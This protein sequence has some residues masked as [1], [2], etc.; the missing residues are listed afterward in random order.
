[1]VRPRRPHID[2]VPDE[3]LGRA[4]QD[5]EFR[6]NLLRA[7]SADRVR[8]TVWDELEVHLTDEAAQQIAS[9]DQAAVEGALAAIKAGTPVAPY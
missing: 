3:V 5:D 6:N 9:L 2:K 1:M 7:G 4:V 8:D